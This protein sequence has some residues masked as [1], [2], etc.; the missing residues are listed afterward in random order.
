MANVYI[1]AD[2][3]P[4]EQDVDGAFYV[5]EQKSQDSKEFLE[6]MNGQSTEGD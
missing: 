6:I 4:V 1:G 5:T 2:G 3:V